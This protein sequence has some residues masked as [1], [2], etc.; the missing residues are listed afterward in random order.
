M[1]SAPVRHLFFRPNSFFG[2]ATVGLFGR[3]LSCELFCGAGVAN[4]SGF[5]R[6]AISGRF[7]E[8]GTSLGLV[9]VFRKEREIFNFAKNNSDLPV[10]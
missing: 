8:F 6:E 2:R 3:R 1:E 5:A 9:S 10:L 4:L 7:S